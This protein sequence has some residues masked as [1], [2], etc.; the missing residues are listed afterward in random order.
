MPPPPA[1]RVTNQTPAG[2]GLKLSHDFSEL[3]DA[4]FLIFPH[5][6]FHVSDLGSALNNVHL[7]CLRNALNSVVKCT[8]WFRAQTLTKIFYFLCKASVVTSL[9]SGQSV[10]LVSGL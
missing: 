1:G 7:I 2:R 10:P 3:R 6:L 5:I 4:P 8:I 9:A